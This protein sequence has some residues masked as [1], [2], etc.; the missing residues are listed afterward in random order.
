M[1]GS[2]LQPGPINLRSTSCLCI[3]D[4]I[5]LDSAQL[6]EGS[7]VLLK[8]QIPHSIPEFLS[9]WFS[10]QL[11]GRCAVYT[12]RLNKHRYRCCRFLAPEDSSHR[13]C[14]ISRN[15]SDSIQRLYKRRLLQ[16]SVCS[17]GGSQAGFLLLGKGSNS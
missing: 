9:F 4:P 13:L 14:L 12:Q 5:Y 11:T 1:K 15:A 17:L 3:P 8:P 16:H 2:M 10:F 7:S 6:S